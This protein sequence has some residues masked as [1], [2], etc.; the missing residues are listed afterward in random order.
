M[1]AVRTS[2]MRML[3]GEVGPLALAVEHFDC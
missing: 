2:M 1:T 3:W